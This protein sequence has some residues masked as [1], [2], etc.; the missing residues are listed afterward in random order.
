MHLTFLRC[1][2]AEDGRSSCE[3]GMDV[4]KQPDS[5]RCSSVAA[6]LDC[7]RSMSSRFHGSAC[8][9][10]TQACPESCPYYPGAMDSEASRAKR[11]RLAL[12]DGVK[13]QM[14]LDALWSQLRSD[15]GEMEHHISGLASAGRPHAMQGVEVLES[16]E[17]AEDEAKSADQRVKEIP[18]AEIAEE[19]P[20][21]PSGEQKPYVFRR[22]NLA[23]QSG[24]PYIV[25]SR[26]HVAWQVKFPKLDSEGNKI[27]WTNR[28]FA[29]KKF[30]GP[31]IT[32]AQA[33]A[34]ALEAAKAFHAELVEKGILSEPKQKDPNFTSEVPGVSWFKNYKKWRVEITAKGGKKKI[35]GGYFAEKAAAEAKALELREKDGLQRQVKPVATLSSLPVFHPKVPYR[36][37]KW[38]VGEQ[39]WHVQCHVRGAKINF[40]VRPKDHSEAELERSFKRAVAWRKKQENERENQREKEGKA[41]KPKAKPRP[42]SDPCPDPSL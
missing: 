39:Q 21:P 35:H 5:G 25:W 32:E 8:P 42:I 30:V 16:A 1:S 7:E 14:D 2:L 27:S 28:V 34:A 33:D 9:I 13:G 6:L 4:T 23:K 31:G 3:S 10:E 12:G 29:V 26:T 24:I 18:V 40:R 15:L 17:L 37:V 19:H 38:D 22:A 20:P 41:V 11:R 36:G